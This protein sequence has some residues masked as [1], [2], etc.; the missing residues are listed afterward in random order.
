VEN[1]IK[2]GD[3]NNN[4]T[5]FK[6]YHRE[7]WTTYR[8]NIKLVDVS[9]IVALPSIFKK[10]NWQGLQNPVF[11]SI[12]FENLHYDYNKSSVK[13]FNQDGV[14]IKLFS[15]HDASGKLWN[16]TNSDGQA[17]QSGIYYYVINNG[18][19]QMTGSVIIVK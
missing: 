10:S 2:T 18:K 16:L 9:K 17:I 19:E 6:K 13:I 15:K 8:N 12:N 7:M 5:I 3:I 11:G 4:L 14:V 1:Y